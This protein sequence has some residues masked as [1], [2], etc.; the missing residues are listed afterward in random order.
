M[1]DRTQ[2]NKLRADEIAKLR[3]AF[4][5]GILAR[6][7]AVELNCT[8]RTVNKHYRLFR[9]FPLKRGKKPK[10]IKPSPVKPQPKS[11]FYTTTFEL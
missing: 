10:V 3:Y 7:M 9:G 5:A 4:N 2:G 8:D 1:K 11:R 6:E